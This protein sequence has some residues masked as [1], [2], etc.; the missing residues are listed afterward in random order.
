MNKIMNKI[1]NS[2]ILFSLMAI[3]AGLLVGGVI[4]AITGQNPVEGILGLLKGGYLTSYAIASTLT[5][6]TPIIS[7]VCRLPWPGVPATLP[8]VRRDR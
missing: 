6:A 2:N 7:P 8:W 1:G 3:L 4:M 5:R